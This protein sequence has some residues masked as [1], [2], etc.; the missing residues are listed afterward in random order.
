M[1]KQYDEFKEWYDKTDKS[2]WNFKEEFIKYCIADVVVL[3]K[4]VLKFRK[5]FVENIK[6]NIDPFRYTTLASLCMA[7]FNNRF[8]PEKTIV[9]NGANKPTSKVCSEWLIHLDDKNMIPEVPLVC[10]NVGDNHKYYKQPTHTF[11]A[12]AFDLKKQLVK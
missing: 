2:N 4:S 7:I 10:D 5:L 6:L 12:D 1:P 9:G 8:L 3:A 11:H